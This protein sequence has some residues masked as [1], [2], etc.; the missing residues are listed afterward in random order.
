MTIMEEVKYEN[1][2]AAQYQESWVMADRYE[3][4]DAFY[5]KKAEKKASILQRIATVLTTVLA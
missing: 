4:C 1:Y 5:E 3:Y 2:K